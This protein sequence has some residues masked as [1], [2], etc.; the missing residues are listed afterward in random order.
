MSHL[1]E[2]LGLLTQVY[3]ASPGH[4]DI[5]YLDTVLERLK[6]CYRGVTSQQNIMEPSPPAPPSGHP[7]SA[8]SP[9]VT[10]SPVPLRPPLVSVSDIEQRLVF[11]KFTQPF[12]LNDQRRQ[13]VFGGEISKFEGR[14]LKQ[15]WLMLFTDLL[16]FT[17]I[18]RD[19]VIFVMEDPV[20]LCGVCQ[21][22]FTVKKK[23]TEFRLIVDTRV[24]VSGA[25]S[26]YLS[27]TKN[28]RSTNRNATTGSGRSHKKT[29]VLR[30]PNPSTKTPGGTT[31]FR[32]NCES[33]LIVVLWI[34][35]GKS[36]SLKS[37]LYVFW[38]E[39]NKIFHLGLDEERGTLQRT[40]LRETYF[41]FCME[42]S[43]KHVSNMFQTSPFAPRR[44]SLQPE[45]HS[46]LQEL[47]DDVSK[48]HRRWRRL[49]ISWG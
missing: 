23:A 26:G 16:L 15:Y 22:I 4:S 5:T 47:R 48:V 35:C 11:T 6:S 38:T 21:A 29:L 24:R 10:R 27:S 32:D 2:V 12:R 20:P 1:R 30:A 8:P 3:S 17:K 34:T 42:K 25:G 13:W 45:T 41:L 18:N 49:R 43:P 33:C 14:H 36:V 37:A 40:G 28:Q 39:F 44:P 46:A 9:S 31:S 7:G 19:R